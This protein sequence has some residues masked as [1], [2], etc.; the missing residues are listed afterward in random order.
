MSVFKIKWWKED[1]G[2]GNCE[3]RASSATPLDLKNLGG[4]F[5]V[6]GIGTCLGVLSSFLEMG[7]HIYKRSKQHNTRY[8][9]GLRKEFKHFVKL[10]R[11]ERS[12]SIIENNNKDNS[13]S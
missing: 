9:D 10:K 7:L 5:F 3:E 6:L 4:V 12:V 2:G 11:M 13:T 8:E 1:R